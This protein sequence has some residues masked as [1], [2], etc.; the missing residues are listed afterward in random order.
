[1]P[2]TT[3][4][5][6]F[7]GEV[8]KYLLVG[9]FSTI[10][11]MLLFNALVHG[12]TRGGDPPLNAHPELAFFLSSVVGMVISFRGTR[13]WAFRT[14][15]VRHP[16]GGRTAFVLI[17]LVTMLIPMAF[18]WF[19]RNVLGLDDPISDNIS[20]NVLGLLT[21]NAV[22]FALFR[23]YVF[24]HPESVLRPDGGEQAVQPAGESAQ[25]CGQE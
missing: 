17:N 12:F 3:G 21:A 8:G 18:L 15:G 20:A 14:R 10:V 9:A 13:D 23:Q 22:R 19:N 16:D 5:R 25:S 1:M 6:K 11:A 4:V 24:P 2:G 7:A